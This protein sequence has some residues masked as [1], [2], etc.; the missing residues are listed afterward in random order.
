MLLIEVDGRRL[1]YSG[2]F[3]RHGRK[4]ALV[5]R[6]MAA[7]PRGS[8]CCSWKGTNLG[9]EQV[10]HGGSRSG[11]EFVDLFQETPG[12]SSWRGPPNVDHT[13]TLYRRR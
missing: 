3:R 9:S 7:P 8:T 10:D 13:V 6:L 2:D 1:F 5:E 11:Q 12:A 4:A